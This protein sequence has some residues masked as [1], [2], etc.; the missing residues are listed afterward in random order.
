MSERKAGII[1]EPTIADEAKGVEIRRAIGGE[2]VAL[3]DPILLLDHPSIAP[4]SP[5]VGFH[6]HPHRGIETLSYVLRG[7]VQHRDSMGNAGTVGVGGAQWMTAGNGI[8][9]EE[10]LI[11]G[12]D[13]AEFIQLWFN[14]PRDKKRIP[15]AYVGVEGSEIPIIGKPPVCVIAGEYGGRRG[16]FQGIAV[17]PTVLDVTRGAGES[18]QIPTE[19]GAAAFA[20]VVR[21]SVSVE[22]RT[23][24]AASLVILTDGEQVTFT[25]GD[26]GA[27]FL[28]VSA[29]PLN[30]PVLQYRSLVMNTVE[31]IRETLDM[32]D[33]G[34]FAN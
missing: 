27:R 12:D 24:D 34:T 3:L 6:R 10:M 16:P 18:I 20:Y 19:P 28:F 2:R 23:A 31:D 32:M 25:A 30:E 5:T 15:A 8:Y 9:H 17:N 4:G 26:A 7:S 22:D 1:F 13:G 11:S 14:L 33:A 21:G 29:Q